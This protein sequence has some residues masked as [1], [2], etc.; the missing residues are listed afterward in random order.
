MPAVNLYGP[1]TNSST[2][3]EKVF[4]I[5]PHPTDE[6]PFVT[7]AISVGTAGAVEVVMVDDSTATIPALQPGV[8]YPLRVKRV[9]SAGTV[10]T[11]IIGYV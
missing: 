10:A 6:L 4:S 7:R 3:L 1:S 5:T 8:L 11:L 2:P 9:V